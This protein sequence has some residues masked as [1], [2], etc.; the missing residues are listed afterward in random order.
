MAPD[1]HQAGHGR[2]DSTVVWY[3]DISSASYKTG[4]GPGDRQLAGRA[5]QPAAPPASPSGLLGSDWAP[6]EDAHR[7]L[8]LVLST[9]TMRTSL[10]GPPGDCWSRRDEELSEPTQGRGPGVRPARNPRCSLD[11]WAVPT[12]PAGGPGHFR[13]E[14][15]G[16][17]EG[18]RAEP[19]SRVSAVAASGRKEQR[20]P[21]Q[22]PTPAESPEPL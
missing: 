3:G 6:S 15:R 11:L 12:E 10:C 5:D 2:E 7:G 17:G 22:P 9:L 20:W 13:G 1:S 4:P 18:P 19:P 16:A 21:P 14:V 8:A